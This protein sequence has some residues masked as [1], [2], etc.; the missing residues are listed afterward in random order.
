M[1]PD[2][3]TLFQKIVN[4]IES[5]STHRDLSF[6][7]KFVAKKLKTKKFETSFYF[8]FFAVHRNIS[9]RWEYE[10][11]K[12]CFKLFCF[13]FFCYKFYSH[14]EW[15]TSKARKTMTQ[16]FSSPNN[17]GITYEDKSSNNLGFISVFPNV[18]LINWDSYKFPTMSSN[19]P[20]P[21]TNPHS[22][23]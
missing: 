20:C 10:K 4:F 15:R 17:L 8:S 3:L 21:P 9:C 19:D 12:S 18:L 2:W 14:D 1:H 13:Q 5:K 7:V 22:T 16:E 11:V 6:S 23:V